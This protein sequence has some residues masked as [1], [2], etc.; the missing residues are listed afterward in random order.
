MN[1]TAVVTGAAGAIGRA[2][3]EVF[4]VAG[5]EVVAVDRQPA[6]E[7]PE[8]VSFYQAD[9][10]EP[11][12]IEALFGG[13]QA[14]LDSL[15]AVVNN[16]SVQ[17]SKPLIETSIEDWDSMMADNLR[18]AYLVVKAAYPLLRA[19]EGA[20][21]NVSSVHGA[22]AT[23][24]LAG[25]AAAKGGLMALTRSMAL[26]FAGDGI[27][28]NAVLPGTVETPM[29]QAD[30]DRGHPGGADAGERLADLAANTQLGRVGQ[31]HE[32]AQA[33]LFLADS[34]QSS[35][36]TAQSLIV[37]GGATARLSTE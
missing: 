14:E 30:L 3:A 32:I 9:V 4:A 25:Y 2:T 24:G 21:V 10:T 8:G 6:G 31:P 34:E 7:L 12:E 19:A 29:L 22:A 15:D 16:A 20:I 26:E 11:A 35:F 5:W 36:M 28:A 18:A 17:I 23:A 27:R 33:I 13:L 37:D 1:R